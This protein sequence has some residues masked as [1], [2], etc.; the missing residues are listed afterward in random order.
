MGAHG[1]SG[2]YLYFGSD[3]VTLGGADWERG[4]KESVNSD[5]SLGQWMN[6]TNNLFLLSFFK[7][8]PFGASCRE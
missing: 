8:V 3:W 2:Q 1:V 4:R 5:K 7:F 6:T